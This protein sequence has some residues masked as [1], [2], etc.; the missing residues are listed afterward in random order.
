MANLTIHLDDEQIQTFQQIARQL[1]LSVEDLVQLSVG[2]YVSRN[3]KFE[4]V[5]EAVLKKNEELYRRL[6]Q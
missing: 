5:A 4:R 3:A 2:E 6:A 1:G